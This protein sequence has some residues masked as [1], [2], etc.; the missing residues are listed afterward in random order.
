MVR[1]G[2]VRNTGPA[3]DLAHAEVRRADPLDLVDGRLQ[4]SR[5]QAAVVVRTGRCL[6]HLATVAQSSH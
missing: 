6:G 1:R 5:A 3:G 4:Y 2:G